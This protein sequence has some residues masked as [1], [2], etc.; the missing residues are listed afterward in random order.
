MET[1][2]SYL[3]SEFITQDQEIEAL[4]R[5]ICSVADMFE[6]VGDRGGW[7]YEVEVSKLLKKIEKFETPDS[8][9]TIAMILSSVGVLTGDCYSL[10]A[11]STDLAKL[12]SPKLKEHWSEQFRGICDRFE[13]DKAF[14]SKTFG[15]DNILTVSHVCSLVEVLNKQEKGNIAKEA[16]KKSLKKAV[17][18]AFDR[19]VNNALCKD[20]SSEEKRKHKYQKNAFILLCAMRSRKILQDLDSSSGAMEIETKPFREYFEST[21]HDHL[22]FSSIPDSRFDPAE[23][24][25]CLEG[26]L[27]CSREAVD[28]TLLKRVLEVLS[29]KQSANSHWRANK[30]FMTGE[31]GAIH[32]PLSVEGANSLMRSIAIMDEHRHFDTYTAMA[33]P[34]I[35]RFWTWLRARSVRFD[36]KGKACV[37]WHSEHVNRPD[38]IHLW[39]TAMVAEFMYSY[40]E[41]LG[42][43]M[44]D[45]ALHLAGL[46]IVRPPKK[47]YDWAKICDEFE[48]QFGGSDTHQPKVYHEAQADFIDGWLKGAPENYSILLYGPPG[49]GKSSFAENMAKALR[50]SF[51]TVTVSDF[52]GS[53]GANVEARAKAIFKTL[54]LQKDCVILF[55]E[56]DSFLLDRDSDRYSR[57]DSLFQFLTPGML[58]KINDLR[59]L[60]RSIFIIATNYE[61]R[62]DAA[63]KRTGRIDKKYLLGLPN[64]ARRAEMLGIPEASFKGD[65]RKRSTLFAFSDLVGA[66]KDAAKENADYSRVLKDLSS[67][68][69]ALKKAK[70]AKQN[71]LHL[72]EKDLNE[73]VAQAEEREKQAKEKAGAE[74]FQTLVFDKLEGRET[75]TSVKVYLN[76]L[77]EDEVFPDK[78]LQ[79]LLWL[80]K[81]AYGDERNTVATELKYDTSKLG[82]SKLSEDARVLLK[83]L[84]F[85]FKDKT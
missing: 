70:D 17:Q 74:V 43:H 41:M 24:I 12:G 40:R 37:G 2:E 35:A 3:N 9:G 59:K 80:Y 53:G 67:A 26:L 1:L 84:G 10:R 63:I 22:S 78:E 45:K 20:A 31:T 15:E 60:K 54:E 76:R 34:L 79:G 47:K 33:L 61:N 36:V 21:L 73:W 7:P 83:E 69:E 25:F 65:L 39:D 32:L 77:D 42:R 50:F 8:P 46:S 51:I 72:E 62:I 75:A 71:P 56:I 30:P 23:L 29:D 66:Q 28:T 38:V 6:I 14:K 11:S 16:F 57:Q 49:T 81:E 13:T 5:T 19:G 55:D 68:K 82:T 27:L 85:R 58:T 18:G 44:A 52:L 48:P 4:H 64:A